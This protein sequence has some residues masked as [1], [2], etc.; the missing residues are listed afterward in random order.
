MHE[1]QELDGQTKGY[2]MSIMKTQAPYWELLGMELVDVGRGWAK[3]R[4]EYSDN[5][6]QPFGVVHGGAIFSVAD[7]SVAMALLGLIKHNE[8]F[9]TVEMKINYLRPFTEGEILS[10]ARI[11]YKGSRIALGDVEVRDTKGELIAKAVSTYIV[12]KKRK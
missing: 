10:E 2:I 12:M 3:V 4:L 1:Y 7:S 5:L 9:T 6:L 11:I 8:V